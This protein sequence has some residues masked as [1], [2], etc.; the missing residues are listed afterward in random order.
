MNAG[1]SPDIIVVGSAHMDV[2]AR[3][4]RLPGAGESLLGDS[5][6]MHPGGKAGNQAIAAAQQGARTAIIARVGSDG[7]G[8]ELRRA[9]SKK[10]VDVT[11]LLRDTIARTGVSPVFMA[12]SGEYASIIVPGASQRLTPE[13]VS[14]AM[15]ALGNCK[16]LMVQLE[17][18]LAT[19]AAAISVG[20]GGAALVMLNASPVSS[21]A[22][23]LKWSFWSDV[24]LLIV[25]RDE[26]SMLSGIDLGVHSHAPRAATELRRRFGVREAVI[27]LGARGAAISS[28]SEEVEISGHVVP[29]I[30]TLGAGDAFAG[31]LAASLV[32][33]D[34]LTS[35]TEFATVV[36]AIAVQREGAYDASPTLAEARSVAEAVHRQSAR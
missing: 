9:L 17:I 30:D 18:D 15:S 2:I 22:S 6:A 33:G 25:N 23:A 14:A 12:N 5:Y 26:A 19:S 4:A 20:K 16:V 11:F 35:A 8:D 1:G 32:R 21:L 3:A 7:F 28:G 24:D 13:L 31:A 34:D 29:V 27:T 36:G 10:L